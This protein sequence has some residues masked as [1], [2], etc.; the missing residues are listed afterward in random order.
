MLPWNCPIGQRPRRA[1]TSAARY[2]AAASSDLFTAL[3]TN[4]KD[5]VVSTTAFALGANLV[6]AS[7]ATLT[8]LFTSTVANLDALTQGLMEIYLLLS[9][10]GRL[11]AV[12]EPGTT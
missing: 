8:A 12:N 6:G 11:K 5:T 1:L 3:G 10:L 4:T 7:T 9:D 2:M